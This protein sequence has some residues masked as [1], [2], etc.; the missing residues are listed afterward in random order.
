VRQICFSVRNHELWQACVKNYQTCELEAVILHKEILQQR[1]WSQEW[2]RQKIWDRS[3]HNVS[4]TFACNNY[5]INTHHILCADIFLSG[6]LPPIQVNTLFTWRSSCWLWAYQCTRSRSN[7]PVLHAFCILRVVPQVILA[8]F[9]HTSYE[10]FSLSWN[11]CVS[12]IS[13]CKYCT[14]KA[15]RVRGTS[16]MLQVGWLLIWLYS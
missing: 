2:W 13:L 11:L 7:T 14:H 6:G 12:C 16:V 8:S 10:V 1:S 5:E 4:F 3:W 9:T 15:L